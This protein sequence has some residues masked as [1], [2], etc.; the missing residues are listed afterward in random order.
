MENRT[1]D[2]YGW[3]HEQLTRMIEEQL[4]DGV[5]LVRPEAVN[6]GDPIR[7]ERATATPTGW[8]VTRYTLL[9]A[10]HGSEGFVLT[11]KPDFPGGKE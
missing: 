9:L 2:V 8:V 1:F 7:V 3:T 4:G 10:P 5:I 11:L 6:A